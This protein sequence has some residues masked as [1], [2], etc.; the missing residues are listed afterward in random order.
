MNVIE[1]H[2]YHLAVEVSP[3]IHP[4]SRYV[5]ACDQF[6]QAST[7]LIASMNVHC[8]VNETADNRYECH[9]FL[10]ASV[11]SHPLG[12]VSCNP[13]H[14]SPSPSSRLGLL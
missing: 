6:Y 9:C 10:L 7:V 1:A 14:G 3:H 12:I 8:F 4:T 5:I 11:L 2:E 13:P